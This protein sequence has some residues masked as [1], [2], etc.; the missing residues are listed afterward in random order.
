VSAPL[1]PAGNNIRR[2]R[3]KR[4]WLYWEMEERLA[5]AGRGISALDQ[6]AIDSGERHVT[7]DGLVAL[8]SVFDVGAGAAGAPRRLPDLPRRTAGWIRVHGVR[9][10]RAT[11]TSGGRSPAGR[12]SPLHDDGPARTSGAGPQRAG[13]TGAEGRR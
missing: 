11:R 8:A 13:T 4:R 7:V 3:E 9:A 10:Q 6:G 1:E 2:L 12:L 5:R